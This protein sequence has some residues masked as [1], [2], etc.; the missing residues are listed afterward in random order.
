MR[1]IRI[2]LLGFALACG[3]LPVERK[4]PPDA[5]P[6]PL[7]GEIVNAKFDPAREPK[8][9]APPPSEGLL[10]FGDDALEPDRP[11]AREPDAA[12]PA[13]RPGTD[14]GPARSVKPVAVVRTPPPSRPGLRKPDR[15]ASRP[16]PRGRNPFRVRYKIANEFWIATVSGG[17]MSG[18]P[19][20]APEDADLR[21]DLGFEDET[22]LAFHFHVDAPKGPRIWLNVTSFEWYRDATPGGDELET[23][24][25]VLDVGFTPLRS[26]RRWGRFALETGF[27]YAKWEVDLERWGAAPGTWTRFSE[28]IE[29]CLFTVAGTLELPLIPGGLAADGRAGFGFGPDAGTGRLDLGFTLWP[30]RSFRARLGYRVE[31]FY[32][33]DGQSRSTHR[34]VRMG[35]HGFTVEMGLHF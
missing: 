26:T 24:L 29:G 15:P 30:D 22:S 12:P 7:A 5:T 17:S 14:G 33:I 19:F 1:S 25:F 16:A 20:T 11:D 3:C 9:D 21:R 10:P 6:A 4:A 2:T 34:L 18:V 28:S 8:E 27:R 31:G 13:E 35:L 32:L 23:D